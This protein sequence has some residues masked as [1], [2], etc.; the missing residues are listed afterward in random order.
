MARLPWGTRQNLSDD[1]FYN[2]T[3]ELINMILYELK[4][5]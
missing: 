1:E 4:D 2:R 3:R 5:I